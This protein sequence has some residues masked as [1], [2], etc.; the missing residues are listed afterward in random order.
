MSI[1]NYSESESILK[2]SLEKHKLKVNYNP[3]YGDL[4]SLNKEGLILKAVG[5]ELLEKTV[6]EYLGL[7]GTSGAVYEKNGDY[8]LGIFSS[9]WCQVMD[10]ASRK[11]CK[12]KNNK[13]ALDSG[14][15]LCHDCCWGSVSKVSIET[16]MPVD[17]ECSGGIRLYAVPILVDDE[18][19]GSINF[20]YGSPPQNHK[21]LKALSQE[22][23]ININ[24]LKK[25][26]EE[27]RD[28]PE[29][30]I[31]QVLQFVF[32]LNIMMQF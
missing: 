30:I 11:L 10:L 21:K 7:I 19:I 18:A 9:G 25:A 20:G 4:V 13:E 31:T 8:S 29:L 14:K 3:E 24:I 6:S 32:L 28:R 2:E 17:I 5:R 1:H 22:Y 23:K 12:T 26:S 27:Y 16:K 15:W